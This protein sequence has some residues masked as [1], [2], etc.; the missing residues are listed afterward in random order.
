MCF[1][2]HRLQ[3]VLDLTAVFPICLCHM[4]LQTIALWVEPQA[5]GARSIRGP[6]IRME[7]EG[8]REAYSWDLEL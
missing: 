2:Q 7:C 3:R 8:I 5:R 4:Y 1:P 6:L